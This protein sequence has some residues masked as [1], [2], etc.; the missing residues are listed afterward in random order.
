MGLEI[1]RKFLLA[2]SEIVDFLQNEGVSFKRLEILQF[3]TKISKNEEIRYRSEGEKFYE[4]VKTGFGL[5][6]EENE[7]EISAAE[8]N[9]AKK[10]RIGDKIY[11][12]RYLFRLNNNACNIDIFEADFS[13]LCTFEIEFKGAL[14]AR[15]FA[16][17]KF[18][19]NFIK[20]DVTDEPRYKNKQIALFGDPEVKFDANFAIK[21]LSVCDVELN[22]P[23]NISCKDG[24]RTLF[25]AVLLKINAAKDAYL[26]SGDD[27]ALHDLRVNLRKTRSLIKIFSGVFDERLC[28]RFLRN[29]KILADMTNQKRDL[30]VFYAFLKRQKRAVQI[31]EFI[32]DAGSLRGAQI[33]EAF[34]DEANVGFLRD[35][36]LF[37]REDSDFYDGALANS[38]LKRVCAQRSR[39][40]LVGLQRKI[41]ALNEESANECFHKIRIE[42]KRAR[43]VF[44]YFAQIFSI[45][46]LQKYASKL[47]SEQE[48]FGALQDRDVWLEILAKMPAE[49][50]ADKLKTKIFK[51]IFSLREEILAHKLKFVRQTRKISRGL[52]VY[53]YI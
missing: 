19:E 32:K 1:E 33:A 43:Y 7:R 8:F 50:R 53:Y 17:P 13:G 47:K 20:H 29:F 12:R 14:E 48:T 21:T 25:F 52:K 26:T 18:L 34:K 31:A 27:E 11:K 46:G 51:Q 37:L 5:I 15:E 10:R 41:R 28:E 23:S 6:R 44:E 3:Y 24:A 40:L 42:L 2:N 35:W 49:I 4:T 9:E 38:D 36:E 16:P 22:F 30:D 39:A 45:Y